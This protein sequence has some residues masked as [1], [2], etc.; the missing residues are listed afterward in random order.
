MSWRIMGNQGDEGRGDG[1]TTDEKQWLIIQLPLLGKQ[2]IIVILHC[3]YVS[4]CLIRYRWSMWP[5]GVGRPGKR[6]WATITTNVCALWFIR[7]QRTETL[8]WEAEDWLYITSP[9]NCKESSAVQIKLNQR[10][11][12]YFVG[13]ILIF[14]TVGKAIFLLCALERLLHLLRC[15]YVT[16]SQRFKP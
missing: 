5:G 8:E 12:L 15:S 14:L 1:A 10:L 2:N 9:T 4:E 16:A 6:V 11:E 3:N 7:W 13:D